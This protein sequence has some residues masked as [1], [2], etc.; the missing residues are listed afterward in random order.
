MIG[1]RLVAKEL[2]LWAHSD[3]EMRRWAIEERVIH[4]NLFE[5][6]LSLLVD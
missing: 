6:D 4:A 5:I 3:L 2:G 1:C